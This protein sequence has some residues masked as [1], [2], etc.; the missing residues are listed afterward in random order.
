VSLSADASTFVVG[1]IGKDA[2]STF[3]NTGSVRTYRLDSISRSYSKI[4]PDIDGEGAFDLFGYS[5]SVS[6]DG[7]TFVVGAINNDVNGISNAGHVRAFQV[8]IATMQPTKAP[9]KFP[10]RVPTKRPTKNPT[11]VPT[12]NPTR[13]PTKR[14]TKNPTRV[15]TK[16]PTTQPTNIPTKV[17]VPQTIPPND[18]GIFGW[19]IFCPRRGKCGFLRRLLK[20]GGC[21]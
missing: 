18:C 9:S 8:H 6:A 5:V 12:K 17:P 10:T 2:N 4:G 20:I 1:A 3:I 7:L 11:R 21:I 13:V 16:K 14:P 19:N 15:P